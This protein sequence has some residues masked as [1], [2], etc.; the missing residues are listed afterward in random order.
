VASPQP[1]AQEVTPPHLL[2]RDAL[3]GVR[4]PAARVYALWRRDEKPDSVVRLISALE[5]RQSRL[6]DEGVRA[7]QASIP[8]YAQIDDPGFVADV[9]AH[10]ERHHA[11]ILRSMAEGRALGHEEM[12]FVR[13]HAT[14]CVGRVPLLDFIRSLRIYQEIVWR[15]ALESA[16]D[17]E[18][19]EAVLRV[20]GIILD[21][22]NLAATH[23]GETYLEAERL[24][25]AQGEQVRQDLLNDLLAGRPVAPGPRMSA[26]REAGLEPSGR[27]LVVVALATAGPADDHLLRSASAALVR[28]IGP[29]VH[30]LTTVRGE[31][32]VIVTPAGQRDP[33]ELATALVAVQGRLVD[34]CMRLAIGVSTIQERLE[35]LPEA[36]RE[37]LSALERV[38]PEG[39]VVAL[40]ALRAFDYLTRFSHD[41]VRRLVPAA[42]RRFVDDDLAEGGVLTSTLLEYVAVDLNVKAAAK[43]LHL[44]AN[45]AHYRLARIEERTGCD[46]RRLA[47]VL[48]LLI[49][50]QAAR[51][52]PDARVA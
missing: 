17:E 6:V 38:R 36:Y 12:L 15:A 29:R 34:Q 25:C 11:T 49:A 10:L 31:E 41:T 40:P 13:P 23:A 39:G 22:H 14:R 30:P 28:A 2:P 43:R 24:L 47:D 51:S 21:Y 45:T 52:A 50:V 33:S 9:R 4:E 37:A 18:S 16:T 19:R 48:D 42:I 44:H 5:N 20:V 1:A 3:A 8:A 7:I 26:A 27:C 35:D 46:L 32:I